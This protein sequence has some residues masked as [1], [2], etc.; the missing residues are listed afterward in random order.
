MRL[1]KRGFVPAHTFE[2]QK[3]A[4]SSI[5]GLQVRLGRPEVRAVTWSGGRGQS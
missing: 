4:R 5:W 3:P 1:C 2:N